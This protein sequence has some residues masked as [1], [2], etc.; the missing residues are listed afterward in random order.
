MKESTWSFITLIIGFVIML[1][2]A[3]AYSENIDIPSWILFIGV[4]LFFIGSYWHF[5]KDKG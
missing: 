2:I 3:I 1:S 4:V 5:R